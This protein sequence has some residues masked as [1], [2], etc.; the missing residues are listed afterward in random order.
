[1][2]SEHTDNME[3][4]AF[5]Y[6]MYTFREWVTSV[7]Q[8]FDQIKEQISKLEHDQEATPITQATPQLPDS[9]GFWRD[10]D[11][12]IWAYD[13]NDDNPPIFLFDSELNEIYGLYK[14]LGT[15]WTGLIAFA[16]FAKVD[17]PFNTGNN[18]AN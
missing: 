6:D 7:R 13:G 5:P 1:M 12:D 3:D 4:D 14:N 17:N 18:H 2:E 11:G 10:K 9:N 16:P 15:S 8:Q